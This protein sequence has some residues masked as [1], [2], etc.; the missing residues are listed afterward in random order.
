MTDKEAFQ[1][2]DSI[3]KKYSGRGGNVTIPDSVTSM[4]NCAFRVSAV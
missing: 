1:I 2:E 3:L 4:V